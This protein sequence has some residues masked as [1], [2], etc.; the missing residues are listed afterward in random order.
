MKTSKSREAM[1]T[2]VSL[3]MTPHESGAGLSRLLLKLDPVYMV[4]GCEHLKCISTCACSTQLIRCATF[5]HL[6]ESSVAFVRAITGDVFKLTLLQ[7][8]LWDAQS[9]SAFFQIAET[10]L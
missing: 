3:G 2:T 6:F 4:T 8:N 1:L 7:A 5:S 9:F 10:S